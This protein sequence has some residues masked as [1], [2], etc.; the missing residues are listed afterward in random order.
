MDTRD[1][2][3]LHLDTNERKG[4]GTVLLLLFYISQSQCGLQQWKQTILQNDCET[5]ALVNSVYKRYIYVCL[6]QN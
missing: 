5:A 4:K 3:T 6:K 2:P 1:Y